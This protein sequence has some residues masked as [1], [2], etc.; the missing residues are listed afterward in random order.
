MWEARVPV[1]QIAR[2]LGRHRST[3]H[4]E[5]S[6]NFYHTSFRDRRGH[7]YR[8]YYAVAANDGAR[9]RRWSQAKLT[10]SPSLRAHVVDRLRRGWTP[11]QI[12]GR[13]A[14]EPE[15][16]GTVSHETIYQLVFSP[17]G[18]R[19]SL[20]ALLPSRRRTRRR[21]SRAPRGKRVPEARTI[22]HRPAAVADREQFGHWEGDLMIFTRTHGNSNV[23]TLVERQTRYT[24]LVA[25]PD[26]KATKV[27]RRIT[28]VLGPLPDEARRT[29]TFDRGFEFLQ[30]AKMPA[31]SYYCDPHKPWQKGGV[32]NT[33]GRIR[34]LLPTDTAPDRRDDPQLKQVAKRLN[35]T[36]RKCLGF[37]TPEEVF[38]TRVKVGG[39]Q[40][41]LRPS[42]DPVVRTHHRVGLQS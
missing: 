42:P 5:I 40:A 1:A 41:R 35:A 27:A 14:L 31:P 10:R 32:E 8:G 36:P 6:R 17:D 30:Y 12:A 26:R 4:R 24:V 16:G 20:P 15:P 19:D 28:E 38:A 11:E 18:R 13:L 21:K 37:R 23:L 33:N 9:R 3:I 2:E 29:L 34:R 7:D 22:H 39:W 25:N